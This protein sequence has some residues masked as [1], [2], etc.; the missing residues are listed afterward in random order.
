MGDSRSRA[1]NKNQLKKKKKAEKENSNT[2]APRAFVLRYIN[3]SISVVWTP[4]RLI[5]AVGQRMANWTTSWNETHSLLH[6]A[7]AVAAVETAALIA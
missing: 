5:L 6:R 4:A 7:A 2:S 3:T 1:S